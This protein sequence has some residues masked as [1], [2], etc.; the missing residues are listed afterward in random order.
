MSKKKLLNINDTYP[1]I[2]L[3]EAPSL[4][5]RLLL[6]TCGRLMRVLRE[7]FSFQFGFLVIRCFI[8]AGQIMTSICLIYFEGQGEKVL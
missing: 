3:S 7:D 4:L 1:V 8:L 5:V 2:S 6:R